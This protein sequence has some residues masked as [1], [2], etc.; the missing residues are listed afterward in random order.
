MSEKF[1]EI[2]IQVKIEDKK[3]LLNFLK[4]NGRLQGKKHQVDE[5]FTPSHRD[6]A[7]ARPINEWLRLRNADGE[8]SINYKHWYRDK[9][10]ESTY[11]DEYETGIEDI[12]KVKKIF[13]I[14]DFKPLVKVDK[15]REI[16]RYGDYEIGIDSVKNLGEFVEI[17]YKGGKKVNPKETTN[18]MIRLLK[19][20]GCGKIERNH[21]GY[22][23]QLLF[24]NE[25]KH[26][27][28]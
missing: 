14:L 1:I 12:A 25:V 15:T 23:F 18:A 9:K 27:V 28:Q 24:P 2:E 10:G 6:F 16:W 20:I 4:K 11:C 21:V 7:S 13:S 26:L 17:E 19:K 3:A 5:Y 8:Y 22:P